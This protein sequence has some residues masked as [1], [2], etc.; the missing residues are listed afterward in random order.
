MQQ[1]FHPSLLHESW[2]IFIHTQ[3][4]APLV[5]GMEGRNRAGYS[6]DSYFGLM[7]LQTPTHLLSSIHICSRNSHQVDCEKGEDTETCNINMWKKRKRTRNAST[8]IVGRLT[9]DPIGSA[10]AAGRSATNSDGGKPSILVSAYSR[11]ILLCVSERRCSTLP[12]GNRRTHA[13]S[14]FTVHRQPAGGSG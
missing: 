6:T 10:N 14:Q 9:D 13:L 7:W 8:D 5:K 4:V 1:G 3:P 11:T 12:C 2:A